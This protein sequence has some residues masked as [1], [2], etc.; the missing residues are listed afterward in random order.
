MIGLSSACRIVLDVLE[1]DGDGTELVMSLCCF[2]SMREARRW[3][4][5]GM[6]NEGLSRDVDTLLRAEENY[7]KRW[8]F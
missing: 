1:C 5:E 7:C 8:V 6:V 4:Q 2:Y 3:I